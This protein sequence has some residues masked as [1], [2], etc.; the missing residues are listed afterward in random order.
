MIRQFFFPGLLDT[1]P[2]ADGL[3]A[4]RQ[5]MVNLFVV[6][7]PGGLLCFDA[8]VSVAGVRCGFRVL[9][10]D[11]RQ[12]AAVFLTHLHLDHARGCRLF[13][14]AQLYAGAGE[15]APW[16]GNWVGLAPV[17]TPV[18]DGQVLAVAGAS[19]RA[20]AT[21][22]HT[23]GAMAYLV[24]GRF[25]FTG[26]AL[27]L[28]DGRAQPFHACFNRDHAAAAESA[29]KLSG[30]EGVEYLLTAHSGVLRK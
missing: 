2:V 20:V 27:R 15:K 13:S 18:A 7:A 9:G 14:N 3:L 30:I 6:Q 1:G 17:F 29:Q 5:G 11:E 25:L 26:D 23:A 8:G 10:L 12:V 22:G 16:W 4:I 21:P 28:Q 19:V 24:A